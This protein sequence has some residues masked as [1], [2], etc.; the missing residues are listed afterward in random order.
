MG[1]RS[2]MINLQKELIFLFKGSGK[3]AKG[4]KQNNHM[5]RFIFLKI[6]LTEV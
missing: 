2:W 5:V 4:L 6:S 3:H 1:V